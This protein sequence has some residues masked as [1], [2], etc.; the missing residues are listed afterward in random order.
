MQRLFAARVSRA[1]H[2]WLL[3][4]GVGILLL[5]GSLLLAPVQ[6]SEATIVSVTPVVDGDEL[7]IDADIELNLT[8]ELHSAVSRGI[9]LHFTLDIEIVARRW[10]WFDKVVAKERRTWRV[11]YNAL[12][13]QWR[14]GTGELS[15][16][17][18]SLE[19]ALARIRQVRNWSVADVADLDSGI[20]YQGRARLRLDTSQ[21]ARPF[22]VDALNSSAWSLATSW[23][24][25]SFSIPPDE[26]E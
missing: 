2:G 13:R 15:L 8:S 14:V 17:E 12:T 25:F 16:P 7:F 5:A 22:Q 26:D 18:T 10:W 3:R 6:A 11:V 24:S 20:E 21:L 9:P 19:D 4:T 1:W 23:K